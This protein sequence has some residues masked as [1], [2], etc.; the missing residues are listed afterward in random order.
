M[1]GVRAGRSFLRRL[2][3]LS[4][5]NRGADQPLRVSASARAD[6]EWWARYCSEW[7]GRSMISIVRKQHLVYTESM[8]SDASGG[9]GCAAIWNTHWFQIKWLDWPDCQPRTITYKEMLPIVVAVAT[10]GR[11]AQYAPGATMPRWSRWSTPAPAR[12]RR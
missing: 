7:N 4:T 2:I 5:V 10:N 8:V 1:Q 9:W 6:V 3:D 11:D 12:S